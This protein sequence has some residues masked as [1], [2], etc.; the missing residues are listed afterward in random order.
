MER[1][2]I[3]SFEDFLSKIGEAR[4][5]FYYIYRGQ[6]DSSWELLPK[7]G[8]QPLWNYLS[9][10]NNER[11]IFES[12]KRYGIQ[13]LTSKP[14]DD[15]DWLALAQ[16]HGLA[17]RFL[18]WTKNPLTALFF[19]V[20]ENR[21]TDAALYSYLPD[22]I[23]IPE[24]TDPFK[25]RKVH[26]FFPKGIS[27]RIVNQRG[28]FTISPTPNIPLEESD[29]ANRLKKFIIDKTCILDIKQKLDYFGVNEFSIFPDLDGLSKYLNSYVM[30][31][32]LDGQKMK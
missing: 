31:I 20:Y 5:R 18:D 29:E 2:K 1:E 27:S 13:F 14:E 21:D 9:K 12:W 26:A 7:L 10:N 3:Y 11:N 24:T 6:S 25:I 30:D 19:A 32:L 28:L 16:H 17:T 23:E 22:K 15:W 4:N 8:R